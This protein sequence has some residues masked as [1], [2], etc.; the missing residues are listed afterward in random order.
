M[1]A[2]AVNAEE[3]LIRLFPMLVDLAKD[4]HHAGTDERAMQTARMKHDRRLWD[5]LNAQA[6]GLPTSVPPVEAGGPSSG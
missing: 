2:Q 5:E 3:W 4:L 6:L 1:N